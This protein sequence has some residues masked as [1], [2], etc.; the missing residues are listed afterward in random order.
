VNDKSPWR[1]VRPM[2][3]TQDVQWSSKE[4][5]YMVDVNGNDIKEPYKFVYELTKQGIV[6]DLFNDHDVD[7]NDRG[8]PTDMSIELKNFIDS[9][10]D[11]FEG[12]WGKSYAS[13][14]E[15]TDCIELQIKEAETHK[16]EYINKDNNI[17]IHE[18]LNY[19]L[20]FLSG[21]KDLEQLK[22]FILD[23]DNSE[24]RDDEYYCDYILEYDEII[25]DYKYCL[26]FFE[27]INQIVDFCTNSWTD[28]T[29]IRLIY[30]TC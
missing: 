13:L 15:I 25:D 26:S 29:D 19:I 18:K 17:T 24:Q 3:P 20:K 21:E 5:E 14:K 27:G 9:H 2:M 22:Y 12:I 6:R 23:V 4:P 10:P 11:E 30:F 8:F 16:Q 28:N 1:W 7:F